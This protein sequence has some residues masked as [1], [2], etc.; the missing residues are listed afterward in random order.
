MKLSPVVA[1]VAAVLTLAGCDASTRSGSNT[2]PEGI[3]EAG[4]RAA[5]K[6]EQADADSAVFLARDAAGKPARL[7]VTPTRKIP[8][9]GNMI[10][11]LDGKY[12][13]SETG[14]EFPRADKALYDKEK[15]RVAGLMGGA[16][17][18]NDPA[19]AA[20]KDHR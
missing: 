9:A 20:C 7:I 3:G 2:L 8:D 15:E 13:G 10:F 4:L 18:T 16:T 6:H 5:C 14:S 17:T 1:A 11:D 12:L 19:F